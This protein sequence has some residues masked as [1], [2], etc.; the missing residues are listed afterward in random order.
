MPSICPVD[1]RWRS[2]HD[3][4]GADHRCRLSEA[5][6]AARHWARHRIR[7]GSRAA[8]SGAHPGTRGSRGA[9]DE[10]FR[11][12]DRAICHPCPS[13]GATGASARNRSRWRNRI[14]WLAW[15]GSRPSPRM[16]LATPKRPASGSARG[17]RCSAAKHHWNWL[18]RRLVSECLSKF[19]ARSTG[20]RLRSAVVALVERASR[21]R[22]RRWIRAA[23]QRA[24]EY[25]RSAGDVLL[26]S[27]LTVRPRKAY[28]CCRSG[29][30][31]GPSNDRI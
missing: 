27:P 15:R 10:L 22:F 18:G 17:W 9:R 5:R 25:K 4:T 30:A 19:L 12:R 8:R 31:A 23:V 26:D 11:Q 7:G 21:T 3:P 28:P 29:T 13:R 20:A 24:L 2:T 16:F 1:C 6:R 14:D